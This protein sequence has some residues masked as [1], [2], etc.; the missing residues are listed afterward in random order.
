MDVGDDLAGPGRPVVDRAARP[1]FEIFQDREVEVFVER[2]ACAEALVAVW[3]R[4]VDVRDLG[5]D[6]ELLEIRFARPPVAAA[7]RAQDTAKDR[8]VLGGHRFIDAR[9]ILAR[10]RDPKPPR[11]GED[12]LAEMVLPHPVRREYAAYLGAA[13]A[14]LEIDLVVA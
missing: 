10:S 13:A 5:V 2:L 14:P 3:E 11:G 6:H 9:P 7:H 12:P 1:M 4:L 8:L